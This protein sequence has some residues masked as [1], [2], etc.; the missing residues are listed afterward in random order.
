[1]V[2]KRFTI[3]LS[4]SELVM[5][6]GLLRNAER[7]QLQLARSAERAGRDSEGR[8]RRE[9]A[10]NALALSEPAI[11]VGGYRREAWG[12]GRLSRRRH[13]CTGGRPVGSV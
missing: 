12:V 5:I 8:A 2:E 3:Q 7:Q 6:V 11:D 10:R 4:E 13:S 1:M 9:T